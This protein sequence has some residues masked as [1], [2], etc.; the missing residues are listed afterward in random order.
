MMSYRGFFYF[1]KNLIFQVNK[2]KFFPEHVCLKLWL[3][4]I[5]LTLS[6]AYILLR[7]NPCFH[8][9]NAICYI[10][11]FMYVSMKYAT[12]VHT[13]WFFSIF[14]VFCS[15]YLSWETDHTNLNSKTFYNNAIYKTRQG[16][17]HTGHIWKRR[18]KQ[19][20]KPGD[21]GYYSK[22]P[23]NVSKCIVILIYYIDYM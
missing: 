22:Y 2:L 10:C 20:E 16:I 18:V 1:F 5:W 12:K 19:Y 8:K 13:I 4:L 6:R 11:K 15:K 3:Y 14:G 21:T 7:D 9:T 17:W 23:R